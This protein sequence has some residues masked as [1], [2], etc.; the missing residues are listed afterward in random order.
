MSDFSSVLNMIEKHAGC[1]ADKAAL[2]DAD[3]GRE[4]TYGELWSY[5]KGFSKRLKAAGVS[6]D[7]GDGYGTRVVV[8]C[9]QNINFMVAALAVQLAG[10]VFVPVEKNTAEARIIEIMEDVGSGI[11]ISPTPLSGYDCAFIPIS[12][13]VCENDKT[14]DGDIV[15]PSAEM[16]SCIMFTTGTTGKSKGVMLTFGTFTT[17]I[18]SLYS[19]FEHGSEQVWLIPSPL[20]HINGL[21]RTI[22]S[23]YRQC[24]TVII[25][26]Y[27]M[28]K[29]FF[30]AIV[31]YGVTIINFLSASTEMYLRSFREELI[32]IGGQIQYISI[33]GS[34]FTK[35]QLASLCEVFPNGKIIMLYGATEA[36]GLYI[37]HAKSAYASNCL[38]Q[39]RYDAKIVFFDEQK[40]KIIQA[41]KE[42]PGL[43]AINSKTKMSGYWNNDEL[44]ESVTRGEYIV[45]SDLGYQGGDGLYYY[46][47]RSD[48]VIT[49]GG[50]KIAP[51]EIEE[52]VNS[53]AG[54]RESACVPVSDPMMGQVPKLYVAMDEGHAFDVKTIMT[55]L[56]S[57]LEATKIPR[58]IEQIDEIPKINGK[59]NRKALKT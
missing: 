56:R 53:C 13:A 4:C 34:T 42:N 45:L 55:H 57:K 43:F 8:R 17:L 36:G 49:S 3:S 31:K 20:S 40:E 12:D 11:F 10:G 29:L 48:D 24:T 44:T 32:K 37:D 25:N 39:A 28:V 33:T 59:I 2:I 46:L 26:G 51:L 50:Y 58:Y 5:I 23:L 22:V 19:A 18:L 21:L 14:T 15:F 35:E 9:T 7:F 54:V 30:D 1:A 41:T 52:A 47:G 27:T 16:L 38:G 6:R